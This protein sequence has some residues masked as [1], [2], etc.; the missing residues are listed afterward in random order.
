MAGVAIMF[1]ILPPMPTRT[2]CSFAGDVENV[3]WGMIPRIYGRSYAIEGDL[4]IPEGGAEG[5]IVAM[6]DFIGGFGLWGTT[7][8]SSTTPTPCWG[9]T[10]TSS[11]P[12]S[13]CPP[14]T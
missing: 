14:A 3:I 7:R 13:R 4:V 1:G 6:A 10:P 2:R 12:R 9:S 8:A 11:R 5:V